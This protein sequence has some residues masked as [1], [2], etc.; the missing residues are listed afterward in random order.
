MSKRSDDDATEFDNRYVAK[1]PPSAAALSALD[2]S[3]VLYV[4][5]TSTDATR[6]LDDVNDELV[7][8]NTAGI[9]VRSVSLDMF[10]PSLFVIASERDGGIDLSIGYSASA[11]SEE[12]VTALAAQAVGLLDGAR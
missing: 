9:D 11:I 7:L 10:G 2:V 4:V 1:L 3:H 8:Y 6:E 12:E 5:P